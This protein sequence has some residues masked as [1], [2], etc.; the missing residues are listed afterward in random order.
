MPRVRSAARKLG[1]L[2]EE[3]SA[4]ARQ[5]ERL[6]DGA[7]VDSRVEDRAVHVEQ[8]GAKPGQGTSF[9]DGCDSLVGVVHVQLHL[10]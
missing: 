7:E 2:L 1:E 10:V 8:H 3:R 6:A 9:H 5:A 4:V